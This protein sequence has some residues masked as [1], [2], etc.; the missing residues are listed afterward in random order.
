MRTTAG[1]FMPTERR[2]FEK[3]A[4]SL[5]EQ[6][7]K[8]FLGGNRTNRGRFSY[9]HDLSPQPEIQPTLVHEFELTSEYVKT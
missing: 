8:T 1:F 3:L 7:E 4:L 5:D 2:P 6:I 9:L